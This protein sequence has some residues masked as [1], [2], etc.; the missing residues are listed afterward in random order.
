MRT[1]VAL[2]PPLEIAERACAEADEILRGSEARLVA[3]E[4]L[5]LTLC[6]LGPLEAGDPERVAHELADRAPSC[7]PFFMSLGSGGVFTGRGRR[8]VL[9]AGP[10]QDSLSALCGLRELTIGAVQGIGL[11]AAEGEREWNPHLTLGR[12][13]RP[14]S[15][16][17]SSE[18]EGFSFGNG[19][20]WTVGEVRVALSGPGLRG[21]YPEVSRI[22]LGP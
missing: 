1:F 7:A 21:P 12:A 20:R 17:E 2:F 11:A 5:H 9:W 15:E 4:R 18:F 16:Q 13:K 19:Q 8:Q 3:P 10:S 6:F 22:A 14:V